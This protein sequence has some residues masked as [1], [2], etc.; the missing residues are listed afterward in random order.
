MDNYSKTYKS[1]EEFGLNSFDKIMIVAVVFFYILATYSI[2][3]NDVRAHIAEN[4]QI[5]HLK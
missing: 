1:K 2:F 5:M 3:I 4:K